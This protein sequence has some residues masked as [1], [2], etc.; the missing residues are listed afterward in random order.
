MMDA[1]LVDNARRA[2]FLNILT[3]IERK[4]ERKRERGVETQIGLNQL[5]TRGL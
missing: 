4:S 3:E 5:Q 1:S 2:Y